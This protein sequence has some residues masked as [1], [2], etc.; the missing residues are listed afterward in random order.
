[1]LPVMGRCGAFV[2]LAGAGASAPLAGDWG[3][4]LSGGVG[5]GLLSTGLQA[6][7]QEA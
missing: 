1:M 3:L 6:V 7:S 5:S 4:G 2:V